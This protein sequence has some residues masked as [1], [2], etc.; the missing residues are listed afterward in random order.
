MK[1]E[2]KNEPKK[3]WQH[4]KIHCSVC[5]RE[6]GVRP[7]VLQ[8]RMEKAGVKTFAEMEKIYVC[9]ECRAKQKQQKVVKAKKSNSTRGV[10]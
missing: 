5:G 6:F 3:E 9:R 7:E 8:K 10:I 1:N 4:T 2:I